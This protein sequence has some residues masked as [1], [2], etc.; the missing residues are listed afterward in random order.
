MASRHSTIRRSLRPGTL[1][2][3]GVL[4]LFG[5]G[6]GPSKKELARRAELERY[7]VQARRM[8]EAQAAEA[9]AARLAAEAA[10]DARIA[11][12]EQAAA[13]ADRAGEVEKALSSYKSLLDELSF[14][15]VREHAVREKALALAARGDP[16]PAVPEEA[17]R[18]AVRA[19]AL[20]KARGNAGYAA[21]VEELLAAVR[22]APW[23]ADGYYNLGLMQE[24][25][26]LQRDAIRSLKLSLVGAP[27]G[28]NSQDVQNKVYELEVLA[29]EAAKLSGL[30]GTWYI[31]FPKTGKTGDTRYDV[32]M[33]GPAFEAR[34]SFG[35]VL[36]GTVRGAAID[37]TIT[38]PSLDGWDVNDCRTPE[39]TV[40]LT[41]KVREDG[42]L[43]TFQH[44]WNN[45][46]STHW[47]ITGLFNNTGRRQGECI[48]VSLEGSSPN[49]F[50]IAR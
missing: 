49:E 25:A 35:G 5:A 12:L 47:N 37:G 39:Y 45:Y 31:Y 33:D 42:R 50:N 24:G 21:A 26:G 9:E 13:G 32:T 43:I 4:F 46:T 44:T 16:P 23:W 27:G 3:L 11:A 38:M 19:Q 29:E 40:P 1:A 41:G 20:V 2:A 18:H 34:S 30:S 17:R 15:P 36:R 8:R 28:E 14:D 10:R 7:E 6:C 22:L 48:S